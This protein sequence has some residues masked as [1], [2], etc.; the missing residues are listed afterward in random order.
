MG[1]SSEYIFYLK[2]NCKNQGSYIGYIN[3][4]VTIFLVSTS[5]KKFPKVNIFKNVINI[6][7]THSLLTSCHNLSL[8]EFLTIY[9]RLK[10]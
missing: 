4:L 8:L 7:I 10:K 3:L 9:N 5:N 6:F 2:R 1:K